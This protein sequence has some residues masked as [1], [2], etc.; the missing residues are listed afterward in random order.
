M[1]VRFFNH[2]GIVH[3]EFLE[4]AQTVN[5]HCIRWYWWGYVKLFVRE[6]LY[7]FV[8]CWDHVSWHCP[9]SWHALCVEVFGLKINSIF[10]PST[11]FTRLGPMCLLIVPKTVTA[12][13]AH[14]FADWTNVHG[15]DDHPEE[16][17]RRGVPAL[18]WRVET[19]NHQV[20]CCKR[21]LLQRSQELLVCK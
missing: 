15:H 6:D 3:W 11:L 12:L 18:F 13:K 16:Q 9:C 1:W 10:G 19:L 5:Q 8:W 20:Y 21:R 2:I 14:R 17:S 7:T 4:Q